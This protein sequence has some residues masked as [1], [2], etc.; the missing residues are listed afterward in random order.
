M[1]EKVK[2]A[3]EKTAVYSVAFLC[4]SVVALEILF[5]LPA[6]P[7]MYAYYKLK[8]EM[9]T[10]KWEVTRKSGFNPLTEKERVNVK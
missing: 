4:L 5:L 3:L 6:L 2:Q 9:P 8:G 7:F 1:K 10:N